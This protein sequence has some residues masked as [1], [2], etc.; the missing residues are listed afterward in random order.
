MMDLRQYQVDV[1]DRVVGADERR[2]MLVAP[3]GSG[4][5]VIAAKI[6][7]ENPNEHVL[8]LAHRWELIHQ[9]RHTLAAFGV[10]AGIILAS[11]PRDPMRRVQVASIQTLHSRCMRRGQDL[12]P[13]G[14]AIDKSSPARGGS[15]PRRRETSRL[16][17]CSKCSAIR[18]AGAGTATSMNSTAM[19]AGGA[20]ITT[21]PK[22]GTNFTECWS[23]TPWSVATRSAGP[24]TSSARNSV[25]GPTLAT[26]R[27]STHRARSCPG[28]GQGTS[29]SPS[30]KTGGRADDLQRTQSQEEQIAQI[31]GAPRAAR[32]LHKKIEGL[33]WT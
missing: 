20:R 2:I 21:V 1:I 22:S 26:W 11:E 18:T 13:A 33:S 28:C 27:R 30:R 32:A 19:G 6:I 7:E 14:L 17:E 5:T 25:T 24:R 16:T 23:A 15:R 10:P 29:P 31:Y 9:P 12:P 8:F 4:K 3:T